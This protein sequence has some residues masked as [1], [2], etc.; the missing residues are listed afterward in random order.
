[1]EKYCPNCGRVLGKVD[2]KY[3]PYCQSQLKERVGRKP[4]PSHL[5]HKVF[6][7]DN[8]RC[9]ECGATNKETT[10]EIDH[11][12][13][14]SKGG[15]ND[16][17]NLQT[18]CKTCNRAKSATIWE[19]KPKNK[20]LVSTKSSKS[21]DKDILA[22]KLFD[23]DGRLISYLFDKFDIEHFKFNNTN[24][25]YRRQKIMDLV[26]FFSEASIVNEINKFQSQNEHIKLKNEYG[27]ACP[28]CNKIITHTDFLI[29]R[30][31]CPYC[32]YK[33]KDSNMINS[34]NKNKNKISKFYQIW[35]SNR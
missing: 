21:R 9:V 17:N 20:K 8:Y 25:N 15:T 1:M 4:I 19:D 7:R 31:K 34:I 6:V 18:L 12:I 26:M 10:L 30:K 28:K 35:N 5:R 23:E 14:V 33:F 13:P 22:V 32:S 29:R 3:C 2:F 24:D 11:I 16:I 27:I